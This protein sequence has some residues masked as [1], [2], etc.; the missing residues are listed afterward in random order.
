MPSLLGSVSPGSQSSATA[1]TVVPMPASSTSPEARSMMAALASCTRPRSCSRV[2]GASPPLVIDSIATADATSP[3]RWPPMPSATMNSPSSAW[4][5]SWLISRTRP[6]S[7]TAPQ[8]N[9]TVMRALPSHR[10]TRGPAV[11]R[12]SRTTAPTPMRSPGRS[13]RGPVTASPLQVVPFVE[14]R[15]SR[16]TPSGP[17]ATRAW[18]CET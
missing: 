10:G 12:S 8:R 5:A 13:R 4:T 3:P 18:I 11:H 7:V 9:R 15:S 14:P 6:T 2:V 16:W 1:Q 17:A